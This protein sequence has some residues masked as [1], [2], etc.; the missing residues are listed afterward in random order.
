M[1]LG[2]RIHQMLLAGCRLAD[3]HRDEARVTR[4]GAGHRIT[5]A[6]RLGAVEDAAW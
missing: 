5:I 2:H 3:M 4:F 6:G 1:G